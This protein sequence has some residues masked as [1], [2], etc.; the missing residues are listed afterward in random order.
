MEIS[1]VSSVR[2]FT[3][4]T[5]LSIR[6]ISHSLAMQQFMHLIRDCKDLG[7]LGK[8][9]YLQQFQGRQRDPED[10]G[11][12]EDPRGREESGILPLRPKSLRS[13]GRAVLFTW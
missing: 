10:L 12:R 6:T 11:G 2:S 3:F 7:G 1:L 9:G 4:Q 5:I 8:E 13:R